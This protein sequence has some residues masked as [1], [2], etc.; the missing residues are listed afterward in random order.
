MLVLLFVGDCVADLR[1]NPDIL[2]LPTRG[3]VR[4][5]QAAV[6]GKVPVA[7]F[8]HRAGTWSFSP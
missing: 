6:S 5:S 4:L 3:R 2:G 7:V 1:E 8:Q